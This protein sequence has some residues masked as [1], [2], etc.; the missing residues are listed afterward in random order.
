MKITGFTAWLV[1]HEPGMPSRQMNFGPG[2]CSTSH[3]VNPVIF[4][5]SSIDYR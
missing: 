4:I 5:Q 2:S 3:A 1:E